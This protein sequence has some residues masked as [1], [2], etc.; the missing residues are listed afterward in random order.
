VRKSSLR[1]SLRY[2]LGRSPEALLVSVALIQIVLAQGGDLL[3]WKGGG[4]GM[5]SSLDGVEFREVRVMGEGDRRLEIPSE[6]RAQERRCKIYSSAACLR[7]LK[8]S[9]EAGGH[10]ALSIEVWLTRFSGNPLRPQRERIARLDSRA[11]LAE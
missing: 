5:F 8:E 10:S 7:R 3:A 2:W 4:F 11:D 6:Y 1:I 9:M